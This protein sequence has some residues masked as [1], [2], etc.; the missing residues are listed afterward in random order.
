MYR[1]ESRKDRLRLQPCPP[2]AARVPAWREQADRPAEVRSAATN[3]AT[4]LF[5]GTQV[6]SLDEVF[7][8]N[9]TWSHRTSVQ[10]NTLLTGTSSLV[11]E[12]SQL[13]SGIQKAFLAG[14]QVQLGYSQNGQISNNTVA[15]INPVRTGSLS[16]QI[17]QPLLQ[18]FGRSLNSR[19]I[20]IA[21]N[22]VKI[23]DLVFRQQVIAAVANVVNL[24][25]DLVSFN[26]DV[27]V[28]PPGACPGREAVQR[29]QKA[30]GNRHVSADRNRTRRGG[31]CSIAA[32]TH[33]VRNASPATGNDSEELSEPHG[34]DEPVDGRCQDCCDRSVEHSGR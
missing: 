10:S 3:G 33:S 21:K 23:S 26:E 28:K 24:Y 15:I 17:S 9:Y 8:T 12:G 11:F 29:Q 18:G 13:T 14:T 34:P 16:F 6:P 20:R 31:S 1:P 2:A 25:S 4:V 27:K 30:G 22:D 19:F 32:G 7:F 5:T